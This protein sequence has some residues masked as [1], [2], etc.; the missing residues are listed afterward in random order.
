[1]K[2]L[3]PIVKY[4]FITHWC[5]E[6]KLECYNVII[7]L[8][9]VSVMANSVVS[10]SGVVTNLKNNESS[11]IYFSANISTLLIAV[12]VLANLF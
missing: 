1:M 11:S 2:T 6:N 5:P 7:L 3:S 12:F 8:V 9:H 4:I 10:F